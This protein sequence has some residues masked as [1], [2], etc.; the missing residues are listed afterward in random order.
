MRYDLIK[1]FAEEM[2]E[3]PADILKE[4][5]VVIGGLVGFRVVHATEARGGALTVRFADLTTLVI[6][7]SSPIAR[8]T[9]PAAE[10]VIGIN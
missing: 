7:R 3:V 8:V 9:G 4:G 6:G 5:D 2:E 1:T 10:K